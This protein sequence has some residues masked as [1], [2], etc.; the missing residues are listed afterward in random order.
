MPLQRIVLH[1]SVWIEEYEDQFT[2]I[3]VIKDTKKGTLIGQ[4]II[5]NTSGDAFSKITFYETVNPDG[6]RKLALN[7]Q[8]DS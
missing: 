3:N 5:T 7:I 8:K 6:T 2:S 1:G 4:R